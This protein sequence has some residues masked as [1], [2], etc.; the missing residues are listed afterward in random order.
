[1]YASPPTYTYKNRHLVQKC[2]FFI[3]YY[4]YVPIISILLCKKVH[5]NTYALSDVS[6]QVRTTTPCCGGISAWHLSAVL[7]CHFRMPQHA[8]VGLP[9]PPKRRGPCGRWRRCGRTTSWRC[10]GWRRTTAG[11]WR[12]C[13]P[14]TTRLLFTEV[15]PP[16]PQRWLGAVYRQGGG[17]G[18][19]D[20][21]GETGFGV[22]RAAQRSTAPHLNW[23]PQKSPFSI[24][25]CDIC[26]GRPEPGTEPDW[27]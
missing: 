19:F 25:M 22:G 12:R 6:Q 27:V 14:P 4:T 7:G 24:D 3:L 8:T 18:S 23:V 13:G 1:M 26:E 10:S 21:R 9:L 20:P 5:M 2:K 16:F 15:C 17:V 11:R